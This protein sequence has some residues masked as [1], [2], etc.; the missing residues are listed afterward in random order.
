MVMRAGNGSGPRNG[1]GNGNKGRALLRVAFKHTLERSGASH[2]AAAR[3]LKKEPSTVR[4]WLAGS[5]RIDVEAIVDSKKL[6]RHFCSCLALAVR[7]RD[8]KAA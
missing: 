1:S 7:R 8:R 2:A 4:R 3:W 6:A 5:H